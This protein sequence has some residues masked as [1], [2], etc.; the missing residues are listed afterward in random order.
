MRL[1]LK[2][3]S[4]DKKRKPEEN[5]DGPMPPNRT[6]DEQT[7]GILI[8][9]DETIWRQLYK[10]NFLKNPQNK[11]RKYVFLEASDGREA[12]R[13]IAQNFSFIKIVILDLVMDKMGGLELLKFL[14][15]KWGFNL[16]IFV[17]T[18]YGDEQTQL[19]SHLRGV[20]G[21]FDKANLDFGK[22]SDLL[23]S[24][25]DLAERPHAQNT[26]FYVEVRPHEGEDYGYV[27]LRWAGSESGKWE[28]LC[29]GRSDEI[30][31]FSLN[32]PNIRT[33]EKK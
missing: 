32:L 16:G 21:F 13:V 33:K 18:A 8:V 19:E 22:L 20:R 14:V 31:P 12:L 23:E 25:L 28:T 5:S 29:L 9:E 17:I 6:S 26:G 11:K 30:E 4:Q 7:C 10:I 3:N 15:D 1:N 24:Y 2:P 27:Y